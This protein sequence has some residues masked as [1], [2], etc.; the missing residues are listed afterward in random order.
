MI[1]QDL[2]LKLQKMPRDSRVVIYNNE[3][4]QYDDVLEVRCRL[5]DVGESKQTPKILNL[6]E[7]GSVPVA[8]YSKINELPVVDIISTLGRI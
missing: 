6:Y 1:V 5:A 3:W 7:Q 2:I 8:Y 4:G